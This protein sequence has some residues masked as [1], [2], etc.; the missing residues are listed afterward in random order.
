MMFLSY[1]TSRRK[2]LF[3]ESF[4]ILVDPC[5]KKGFSATHHSL[6]MLS[7]SIHAELVLLALCTGLSEVPS[8]AR[9]SLFHIYSS[10]THSKH[11]TW[12][13]YKM[14]KLSGQDCLW[15]FTEE[16]ILIYIPLIINI[17]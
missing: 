10:N 12:S 4:L 7:Y 2:S 13:I 6:L 11:K 15:N 9:I 3:D 16:F 5:M 1:E 8:E 17:H 14:H